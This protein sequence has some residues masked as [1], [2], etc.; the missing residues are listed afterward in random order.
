MLKKSAIIFSILLDFALKLDISFHF[1]TCD[2][3]VL[4]SKENSGARHDCATKV[5]KRGVEFICNLVA[6]I[7]VLVI[8]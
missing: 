8:A 7:L 4:D 3:N 1:A 6:K 5:S 2:K